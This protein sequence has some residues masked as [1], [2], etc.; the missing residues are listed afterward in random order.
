M[1]KFVNL[2]LVI[3]CAGLAM[4]TVFLIGQ[5]A[6]HHQA[7]MDVVAE[8]WYLPLAFVVA[9]VLAA[10]TRGRKQPTYED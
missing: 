2:L 5:G 8:R 10:M 4:L 1:L 6:A 3:V 7:V 9:V